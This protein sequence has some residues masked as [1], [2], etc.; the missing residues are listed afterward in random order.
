MSRAMPWGSGGG[1]GTGAPLDFGLTPDQNPPIFANLSGDRV[2][3]LL[4]TPS[5]A[6]V[7]SSLLARLQF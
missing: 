3:S 2:C 1:A 5:E 6:A 7:D 4:T